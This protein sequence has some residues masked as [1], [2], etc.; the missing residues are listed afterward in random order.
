MKI[1]DTYKLIETSLGG[2]YDARQSRSI[3]LIFMGITPLDLVIRPDVEIEIEDFQQKLA[4]LSRGMP[5][6][7]VMG[8]EEFLGRDF[9]VNSSTLIPRPETEELVSLIASNHKN[10]SGLS[11]LDIGTGSG[12][13]AITLALELPFSRVMGW[14]I[15]SDALAMA[16]LNATD[17]GADNVDFKEVDVLGASVDGP[18]Y[19]IIVSN[20]PYVTPAQ[21]EFMHTNVLDYEPHSALFIEQNDPLLFYRTIADLACKGLLAEGGW[22]YFEINELYPAECLLLLKDRGFTQVSLVHDM[23]EKPRIVLGKWR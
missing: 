5:V 16:R 7:Y 6:Q 14:D 3:A 9:G 21:A 23:F 15:S 17:L 1:Y 22:L 18:S 20:P 19:D 13:I 2:L 10:A 8:R 12:A 11:V 4:M